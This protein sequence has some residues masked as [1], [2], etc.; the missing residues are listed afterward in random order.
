MS[1]VAIKA[2]ELKEEFRRLGG[3][4]GVVHFEHIE[5]IETKFSL[6]MSISADM[7]YWKDMKITYEEF[8]DML[9]RNGNISNSG[10]SVKLQ[11]TKSE[12]EA[13]FAEM[14]TSHDGI[15]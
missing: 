6:P 3:E 14:D 8:V 11:I 10:G 1:P 5:A 7:K 4:D 9:K 12:L 13:A 15:I 2:S